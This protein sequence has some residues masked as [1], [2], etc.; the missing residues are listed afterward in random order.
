MTTHVV[1]AFQIELHFA[2]SSEDSSTCSKWTVGTYGK[3]GKIFIL[4]PA[5]IQLQA[6]TNGFS[7]VDGVVQTVMHKRNNRGQD[8]WKNV[9]LLTESRAFP[10]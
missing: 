1:G 10:N 4:T 6:N 9:N 5:D 8:G 2:S 3:S 7:L